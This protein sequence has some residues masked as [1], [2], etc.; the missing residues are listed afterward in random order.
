MNT[1][2]IN[3]TYQSNNTQLQINMLGTTRRII[4]THDIH[5]T[6]Y[7]EIK[8]NTAEIIFINNILYVKKKNVLIQ[9]DIHLLLT[10]TDSNVCCY[11]NTKNIWSN[12]CCFH[13]TTDSL[14]YIEYDKDNNYNIVITHD[15]NEKIIFPCT[16]ETPVA[17]CLFDD[18]IYICTDIGNLYICNYT[19]SKEIIKID[20]IKSSSVIKSITVGKYIIL[21]CFDNGHIYTIKND[22]NNG[23][24]IMAKNNRWYGNKLMIDT[25]NEFKFHN[26]EYSTLHLIWNSF[27]PILSSSE[28]K[29]LLESLIILLKMR[30]TTLTIMGNI[31]FHLYQNPY[32]EYYFLT[33]KLFEN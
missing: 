1:H 10:E 2:L 32:F 6:H 22:F 21:I 27:C 15:I 14:T 11:T 20:K 8:L 26:K 25:N 4:I 31:F 3:A 7:F 24:E 18:I 28:K 33:V 30:V 5:Y 9:W 17:L 29:I 19:E 13:P 16:T 12:I 23:L